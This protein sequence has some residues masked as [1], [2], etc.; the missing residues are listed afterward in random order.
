M[1]RQPVFAQRT[2]QRWAAGDVA[3][4]PWVMEKLPALALAKV[5]EGVADQLELRAKI[6]RDYAK[7][8]DHQPSEARPAS[9]SVGRPIFVEKEIER[10]VRAEIWTPRLAAQW[11]RSIAA[12]LPW[13]TAAISISALP[14][15]R[16]FVFVEIL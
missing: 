8:V 15:A 4:P 6:I 11:R 13:P 9:I 1:S 16:S 7:A 5:N 3:V 10:C 14:S 2:V 12:L